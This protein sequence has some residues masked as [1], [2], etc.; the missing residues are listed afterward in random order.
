MLEPSRLL[1]LFNGSLAAA[2]L[3]S[4]AA[5]AAAETPP[6]K[7]FGQPLRG[8]SASELAAFN[9]GLAQ[10]E[11][12]E[13][14]ATGLGPLYNG[15]SCVECHSTPTSG[16]S[17][18]FSVTRFGRME[19]TQ[20]DPLASLDGS[21]LH[22]H[23][24]VPALQEVL[25][26]EANVTA[27]RITTPSYGDGLIDAIPDWEII[28]NFFLSKPDHVAGILSLVTEPGS[29]QL[30]VGRFGWKAQHA[31]LLAFS[32]DALNN[33][34]GITNRLY[35]TPHAPD[36]NT[37]LLAQYISLTAPPED[38]VDLATGKSAL[39]R[40]T[41]FM[42]FLAP[43]PPAPPTCASLRGERLFSR[44]GCVAC[45]TPRYFTGPSS[46]PAL[47]YKPLALY[48]DLLLHDM[49]T[50]G[51]G[52]GQASATPSEMRTAPLWGVQMRATY[53]HD[54]RAGT[55]DAAILDHAGEAAISRD[56]YI[57]LPPGEQQDLV[58]FLDTL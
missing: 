26:A 21:L 23:A 50:L 34:M 6:P 30:R 7:A 43:P 37:S 29:S 9:A 25:P 20:F 56:R 52:I 11:T 49:G 48:S 57:A 3:I 15:V 40:V 19:G 55:L 38:V 13:T 8:L 10:F 5:I 47:N 17:S 54:G 44:V 35:P 46:S 1:F 18:K 27:K 2:V 36:G 42:R 28:A 45:H 4:T 39:D 31:S 14:P 24:T 51:D 32:A 58:A 41:D 33:E 22:S 16:G 12:V 53:L